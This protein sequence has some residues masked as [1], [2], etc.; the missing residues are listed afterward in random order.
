MFVQNDLLRFLESLLAHPQLSTD[1]LTGVG[2]ILGKLSDNKLRQS[3][4]ISPEA[5]LQLE[6]EVIP[7]FVSLIP[8]LF[9]SPDDVDRVCELLGHFSRNGT[10]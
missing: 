1:V 6:Q 9:E 4:T 10:H 2:R 5:V 8:S 7:A 3:Y